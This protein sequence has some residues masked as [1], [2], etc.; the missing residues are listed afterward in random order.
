MEHTTPAP[1]CPREEDQALFRRVWNRVMPEDRAD[2]PFLVLPSPDPECTLP[3]TAPHPGELLPALSAPQEIPD[4]GAGLCLGPDCTPCLPLLREMIAGK[5]DS[6]RSYRRLARMAGSRMAPSLSAIAD[7]EQRHARR[8]YAAAF[9]ISGVRRCPPPHPDD[10]HTPL[11]LPQ[12]LRRAFQGEQRARLLFQSA[13]RE[14]SDPALRELF[15]EIAEED[16]AHIR[17][18]RTLVERL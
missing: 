13:A 17:A 18:F 7:D 1:P 3:C 14:V 4:S 2:C 16:G 15:S 5:L 9:L 8:L 10:P 12:G 6:V 11:S